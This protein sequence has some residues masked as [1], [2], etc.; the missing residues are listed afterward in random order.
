MSLKKLSI[1]LK[2]MFFLSVYIDLTVTSLNQIYNAL[3]QIQIESV[4]A[5]CWQI[6][7]LATDV[8]HSLLSR[9][10]R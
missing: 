1:E 4:V 10:S 3:A 7:I 8:E 9:E 2:S 5:Y 6:S